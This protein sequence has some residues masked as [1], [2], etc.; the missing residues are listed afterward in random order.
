[1]TKFLGRPLQRSAPR[2]HAIHPFLPAAGSA[3]VV[4]TRR[5]TRGNTKPRVFTENGN[6]VKR[7]IIS[8]YD[9]FS[10]QGTYFRCECSSRRRFCSLVE[11]IRYSH[12]RHVYT[13]ARQSEIQ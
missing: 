12:Y 2:F 3:L 8:H 7:E 11:P 4:K 9:D 6:Q 1:M 13:R 10:P 5:R